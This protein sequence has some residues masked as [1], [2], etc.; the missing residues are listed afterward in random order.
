[1]TENTYRLWP[2]PLPDLFFSQG[3]ERK[4]SHKSNILTDNSRISLVDEAEGEG[5]DVGSTFSVSLPFTGVSAA[6]LQPSVCQ[7]TQCEEPPS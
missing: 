2:G 7:G 3:K 5:R 1:M 6:F 4:S